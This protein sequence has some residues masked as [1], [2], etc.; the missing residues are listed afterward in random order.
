M[1]AAAPAPA[2][3]HDYLIDASPAE[4]EVLGEVVIVVAGAAPVQARAEDL[5]DEVLAR[6]AAGERLKTAAKEVA[7][8][9]TGV[10]ASELYD[11]ALRRR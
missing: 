3:A 7:R 8:S 2:A 6:A 11:L 9:H 1:P 4:G 10:G 5:V